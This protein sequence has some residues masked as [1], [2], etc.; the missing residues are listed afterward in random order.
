ME[1]KRS[2]LGI[3]GLLIAFLAVSFMTA[4]SPSW[5]APLFTFRM[6]Q[7]SGE[8]NFSPMGVNPFTYNTASGYTLH[9]C[10]AGQCFGAGPLATS[11]SSTC[12]PTCVEGCDETE[13]YTCQDTCWYTCDNPTCAS[14]CPNTCYNTCPLTCA[15]CYGQA[16]CGYTCYTCVSKTC[17]P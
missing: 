9:S 4:T 3:F 8:M 11:P 12:D 14:T 6:E 15:T 1:T 13:W 5:N 17:E 10:V 2:A 16:T 7:A